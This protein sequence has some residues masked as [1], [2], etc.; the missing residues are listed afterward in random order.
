[1]DHRGTD[2][3]GM[4]ADDL[5]ATYRD[6][7]GEFLNP[8]LSHCCRA[9]MRFRLPLFFRPPVRPFPKTKDQRPKLQKTKERQAGKDEAMKR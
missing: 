9:A 7:I 2:H 6:E 4:T 3:D 1:M 5:R 8:A